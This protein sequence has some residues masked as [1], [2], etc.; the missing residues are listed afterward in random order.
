M[1]SVIVLTP[2]LSFFY[3]LLIGLFLFIVISFL[4]LTRYNL[5]GS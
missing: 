3:S 1:L 5:P 2:R 4:I